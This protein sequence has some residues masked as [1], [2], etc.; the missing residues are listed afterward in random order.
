MRNTGN[1]GHHMHALCRVRTLEL[2]ILTE[3]H[4]MLI[5]INYLLRHSLVCDMTPPPQLREQVVHGCHRPQAAL[6][7]RRFVRESSPVRF[8]FGCPAGLSITAFTTVLSEASAGIEMGVTL[9]I[10]LVGIVDAV[11]V[12]DKSARRR[13]LKISFLTDFDSP[14]VVVAV[15]GIVYV[16]SFSESSLGLITSDCWSTSFCT[17]LGPIGVSNGYSLKYLDLVSFHG[18]FLR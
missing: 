8:M 4:C 15:V 10:R 16:T 13:A 18:F 5:N 17:D 11:V 6:A 7:T 14:V 9:A 12:A 1:V 2:L 3:V